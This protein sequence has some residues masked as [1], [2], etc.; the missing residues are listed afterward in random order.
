[1]RYLFPLFLLLFFVCAVNAQCENGQCKMPSKVQ[2]EPVFP[3]VA[4]SFPVASDV[5]NRVRPTVL[6]PNTVAIVKHSQPVRR[7]VRGPIR[8]I[9]SLFCR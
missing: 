6:I 4:E 7:V 9:R 3:L 1:M 8:R 2:V 5:V